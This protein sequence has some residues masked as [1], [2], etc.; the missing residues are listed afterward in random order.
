MSNA[1]IGAA[2]NQRKLRRIR[3]FNR[4]GSTGTRIENVVLWALPLLP[5][6]STSCSGC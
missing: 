1:N 2:E 4:C 5:A 3:V 6:L